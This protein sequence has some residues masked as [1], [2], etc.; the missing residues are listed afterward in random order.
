[1]QGLDR[2]AHVIAPTLV[3]VA[4][5]QIIKDAACRHAQHLTFAAAHIGGRH[6]D[7]LQLLR[8]LK[9]QQ[10]GTRLIENNNPNSTFPGL[11]AEVAHPD[12]HLLDLL[13]V[14]PGN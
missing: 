1:V 8:R 14:A 9:A 11:G 2:R 5:D 6:P 12:L 4:V 13:R 10:E 3:V 7:H